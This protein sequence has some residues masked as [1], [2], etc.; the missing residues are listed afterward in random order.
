MIRKHC[1]ITDPEEIRRILASTNIG[2]LATLGTD[3][4][5]YITPVNFVFHEG[6]IYFHCAVAGEKLDN[7]AAS[8]KVCFEVDTPL[9][10][11]DIKFNPER[12]P[13]RLHQLYRCVIIRGE[14]RVL[15]DG[16][17]KVDALNALTAKHEPDLDF[18]PVTEDMPSYKICRVIEIKPV[19]ISAK[20]DLL[21]NKNP[22]KRSALARY[23]KKRNRP[24]DEETVRAMGFDP[25][26]I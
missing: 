19:S 18:T 6:N 13:C 7:M 25:A 24:E 4:Y 14:A 8:P 3:G 21:Q 20:S 17:L 9:A 12:D 1:E 16:P 22:D 2:R 11:L 5:P 23:L 15:P 10:Y 26:K